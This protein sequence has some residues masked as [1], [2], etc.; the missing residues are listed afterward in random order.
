VAQKIAVEGM[1]AGLQPDQHVFVCVQSQAFGRLIYPQGK[2]RPDPTGRWT[3]ESIY[4]TPGYR[5][6]TYLVITSNPA[7]VALLHAQ[8]SRQYGLHALPPSTERL[9]PAIV[10]LRE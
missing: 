1:I 2:V 3:V 7:S 4:G 8:R 9:G 6:A 10:V 5:Y